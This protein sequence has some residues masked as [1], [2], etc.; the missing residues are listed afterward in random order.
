VLVVQAACSDFG[1]LDS[2]EPVAGSRTEV[3]RRATAQHLRDGCLRDWNARNAVFWP[4]L[5]HFRVAGTAAAELPAA[6]R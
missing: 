3:S 2:P 1:E 4:R 6:G 5:D